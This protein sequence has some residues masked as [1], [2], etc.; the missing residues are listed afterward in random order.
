MCDVVNHG[1]FVKAF[2]FVVVREIAPQF[3][4]LPAEGFEHAAAF[5]S[6]FFNASDARSTRSVSPELKPVRFSL[7]VV[8]LVPC[9][10]DDWLGFINTWR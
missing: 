4:N 1:G 6:R 5:A 9:S 2:A 3:L 7:A 8:C 10:F